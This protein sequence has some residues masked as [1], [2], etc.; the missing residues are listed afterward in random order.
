MAKL[1]IS[2]DVCE[3]FGL[4][5]VGRLRFLVQNPEHPLGGGQGG[6]KLA[7]DF[8]Q[9]PDG[10]G[11][12][13]GIE[14]EGGNAADVDLSPQV[15][16]GAEDRDQGQSQVVDGVGGGAHDAGVIIRLI[17]SVH[18]LFVLHVHFINDALFLGIGPE[19]FLSGDHLLHI[20]V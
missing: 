10:A 12:F 9:L 16:D 3:G 15:E 2:L 5:Q 11:K 1:H 14:D 6:L 8:R 13:P 7:V 4:R 19:R 17:V 20:S 18:Q